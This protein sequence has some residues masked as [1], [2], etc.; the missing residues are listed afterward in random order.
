MK[1]IEDGEPSA[2]TR[3]KHGEP[4]TRADLC[5]PPSGAAQSPGREGSGRV[6]HTITCPGLEHLGAHL[7]ERR[8]QEI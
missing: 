8:G 3:E 7:Q 5:I 1:A 4:S 6:I 2:S